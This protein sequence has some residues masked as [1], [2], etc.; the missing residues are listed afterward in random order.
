MERPARREQQKCEY[1]EFYAAGQA[2]GSGPNDDTGACR[3][4]APRG[5]WP[6]R[7]EGTVMTD[8]VVS[9]YYWPTVKETDWCG[10][11]ERFTPEVKEG[12]GI[13]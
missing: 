11:F 13:I 9:E 3:R 1:C 10:E 6:Y 2:I 7:A 4:Y 5:T 12:D 8:D